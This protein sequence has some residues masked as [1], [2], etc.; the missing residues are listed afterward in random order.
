M[1]N[2]YSHIVMFI[3][4]E[5][6]QKSYLDKTFEETPRSSMK[7]EVLIDDKWCLGLEKGGDLPISNQAVYP[8]LFSN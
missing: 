2:A 6:N 8:S 5:M 3:F 1:L 7:T 4:F